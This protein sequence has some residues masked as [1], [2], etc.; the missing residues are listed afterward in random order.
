MDTARLFGT[1]GTLRTER[2]QRAKVEFRHS[3]LEERRVRDGCYDVRTGCCKARVPDVLGRS[4]DGRDL[5]STVWPGRAD[6]VPGTA[7][8][9]SRRIGGLRQ[10]ALVGTQDQS[11]RARG[12][13]SPCE[14]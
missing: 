12:G 9:G 2:H 5:E 1:K 10:R 14:V 4:R 7:A 6:S 3:P 8:G 13:A 11:A